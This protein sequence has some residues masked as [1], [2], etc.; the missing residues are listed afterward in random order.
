LEV[1]GSH[2]LIVRLYSKQSRAFNEA[3]IHWLKS[4]VKGSDIKMEGE[5]DDYDTC[6]YHWLWTDDVGDYQRLS[7]AEVE[8]VT[9]APQ[10]MMQRLLDPANDV[11]QALATTVVRK[12][13]QPEKGVRFIVMITG[14]DK[15]KFDAD[16]REVF[17]G[18]VVKKV[19]EIR[20]VKCLEAYRG[21][22][23]GLLIIDGRVD[24]ID[25]ILINKL[26]DV[27]AETRVTTFGCRAT[28][29]LC[30]D[31]IG[32]SDEQEELYI[33]ETSED[34]LTDDSLIEMLKRPENE[35]FEIKGSLRMNMREFFTSG[36]QIHIKIERGKP[37][38]ILKTISA[39]AN[40]AGGII[41]VGAR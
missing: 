31:N 14:G 6:L 32:G 4:P 39:F 3:F 21:S 36:H 1:Y 2:D 22:S 20:G 19:R 18:D 10:E 25:Y 5:P 34:A 13:P 16:Q 41:I 23:D 7:T 24:Y 15:G 11:D 40:G 28:T 33:T 38:P 35:S 26:K 27:I 17:A 30:C 9:R 8:R 12:E 37:H 29:Y